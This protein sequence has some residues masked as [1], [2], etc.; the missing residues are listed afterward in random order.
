MFLVWIIVFFVYLVG[1][2][3]VIKSNS[4]IKIIG[5]FVEFGKFLLVN[6]KV[7]FIVVR[8]GDLKIEC[9]SFVLFRMF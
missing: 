8:C 4:F 6:R 7:F 5:L 3:R 2:L 1:E 9:V